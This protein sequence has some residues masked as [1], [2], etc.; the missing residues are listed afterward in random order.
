MSGLIDRRAI[1]SRLYETV[2]D[3]D[4]L[5]LILPM[6]NGGTIATRK[7]E[8]IDETYAA[9]LTSKLLSAVNYLHDQGI[10]HRDIK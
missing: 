10:A 9:I 3:K 4:G 1:V 6:C 5:Y 8:K 2:A 7:N